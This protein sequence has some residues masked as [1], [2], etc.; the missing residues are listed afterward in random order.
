MF[1]IV[2]ARSEFHVPT[3]AIVSFS[4][5]RGG[6]YAFQTTKNSSFHDS[7]L[8]IRRTC[9]TSHIVL[10]A[11]CFESLVK[12]GAVTKPTNKDKSLLKY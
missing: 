4:N 3:P 6:T 2:N 1:F 11:P 12:Q 7:C 8:A 5:D 10:I 9:E